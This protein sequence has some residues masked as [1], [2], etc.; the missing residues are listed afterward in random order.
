MTEKD[1]THAMESAW[2]I[3]EK[4]LKERKKYMLRESK[5]AGINN[6][7]AECYIISVMQMLF[8]TKSVPELLKTYEKDYTSKS[9]LSSNV[10]S[11]LL[12]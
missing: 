11:K 9:Y 8:M 2:E 7:G 3:N 4:D 1:Y 12:Y 10:K 6:S 5:M